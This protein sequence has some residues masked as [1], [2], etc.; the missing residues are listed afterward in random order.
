MKPLIFTLVGPDKP[1]LISN[2]SK[3]V[4]QRNGNWLGSNFSHMAGHFAGFVHIDLPEDKHAELIELFSQHPDLRIHLV[5]AQTSQLKN[6]QTVEITI[7]GNDKAGIVQELTR[8]LNQFNLNIVKF[9]SSCTSAPNSGSPLFNAKA[10]V[11]IAPEVDLS[12][13]RDALENIANDLMID[14]DLV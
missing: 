6:Q 2:L 5:S 8:V 9:D 11:E 10:I 7:M 3:A 13:L 4:Y 14:V 12:N 1:G